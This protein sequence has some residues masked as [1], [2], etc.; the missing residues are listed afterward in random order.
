MQ[1]DLK[2]EVFYYSSFVPHEDANHLFQH[3][4][5]F[6]ELVAPC[7]IELFSGEIIQQDY[8][9]MMM[10]DDHIIEGGKLDAAHSQHILP[11]SPEML[12][13]KNKIEEATSRVFGTCVCIYYPDGNS[14]VGYHSDYEAFG[15][16]NCLPSL[17]LGEERLFLMREKTTQ[18][19]H[20]F[21]LAN[22]SLFIMGDRCQQLY[23]HSLPVNPTY[24][25][26]RIN[27]TFRPFG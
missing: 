1:I 13:I 2:C 26:P 11:W 12:I 24:K 27:I 16:T 3:L 21:L 14:G 7:F 18:Q 8:G 6:S 10:V 15:N 23:E 25:N 4:T 19:E 20:E 17:S 22:G 5:G 9:K